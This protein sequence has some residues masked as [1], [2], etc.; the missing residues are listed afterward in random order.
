MLERRSIITFI[1]GLIVVA[2]NADTEPDDPEQWYAKSYAPLWAEVSWDKMDQVSSHYDDIIYS[3]E[4]SGDIV[5]V[6]SREWLTAKIKGWRADG[7]IGSDLAGLT[8]DRLNRT[9]VVFK[10]RWHD[11]YSD[12]VAEY[13]CAW[14]M[15]NLRDGRWLFT[16][17]TDIDCTAHGF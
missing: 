15:A 17:Y 13:S 4:S 14:Y 6:Q 7:W 5:A 11:R 9:T 12:G 3:H 1:F 2:A 16:N 8:V 10:S